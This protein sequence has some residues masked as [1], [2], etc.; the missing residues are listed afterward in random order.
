LGAT[1]GEQWTTRDLFRR[2]Y[3]ENPREAWLNVPMVDLMRD[4]RSN[5]LPLAALTNDLS[6]FHGPEWAPKQDFFA[7]FQVIVDAADTGISKPDPRAF[8]AGA[9]ALGLP[10]SDIV[11]IDDMPWNVSA[12]AEFGLRAI[13]VSYDE[14]VPA[15]EQARDLLGL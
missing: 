7:L 8:A 12:A 1:L 5:G 3:A 14:P 2:L 15:I 4:A 10:P 13:H 6:G 9:D 11:F